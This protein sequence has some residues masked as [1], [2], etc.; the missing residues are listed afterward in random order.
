M[1]SPFGHSLCGVLL[2]ESLRKPRAPE[3]RTVALQRWLV[4]ALLANLP[5][6]DFLIGWIVF[7]DPRR[8]HS[9][10]THSLP[11]CVAVA[12]AA[13]LAS[14]RFPLVPGFGT[15]LALVGSH[16][17]LDA[18]SGHL[19]TGPGYGVMA[20]YPFSSFRVRSPISLFWGPQHHD[21]SELFGLAN[22]LGVLW[23]LA[24]FLPPLLLLLR[25]SRKDG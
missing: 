7:D 12:A 8:L 5:D 21:L 11:F 22:V 3:P 19:L 9:G 10:F 2:G 16:L 4:W 20:F 14:R 1:A 24:V 13:A 6:I 23:E 15:A 25:R 17:L 18:A